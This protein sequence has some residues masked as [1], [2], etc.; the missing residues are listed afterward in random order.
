MNVKIFEFFNSLAGQSSTLDQIIIFF[1]RYFG[2]ALILFAIFFLFFHKHE[3]W[4]TEE[5]TKIFK[6][7]LKEILIV[8]V[9]VVGAGLIAYVA[10]NVLAE[11]RPY[12]ILPKVN[13]LFTTDSFDSFPSGHMTV[14]AALATS[15]FLIHRRLGKWY[16]AGAVLIGLARIA[17]GV[18]FPIDILAGLLLGL[19]VTLVIAKLTK[20]SS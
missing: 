6:K 12:F 13:L 10:K 8:A 2:V 18:H 19:I 14:F 7:R 5:P 3:E 9:A 20:I 11:P 4:L 17:A 15:L 16:F 1:A